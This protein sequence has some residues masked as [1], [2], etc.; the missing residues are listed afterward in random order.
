V[1]IDHAEQLDDV[2]H[3]VERPERVAHGGKE[4]EPDEAG[5]PIALLDADLGAELARQHV[6]VL[7][8]GA[9]ARKVQD[10]PHDSVRHV[11][12]D[13]LRQRRQHQAQLLQTRFRT[14]RQLPG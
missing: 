1:C 13:R 10:V 3:A 6:A 4:S 12:G 7:V 14:H 11:I 2:V 9:L 8:A 5:A